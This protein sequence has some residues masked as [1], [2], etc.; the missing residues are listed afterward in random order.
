EIYQFNR[1]KMKFLIVFLAVIA[2]AA[3]AK[4]QEDTPAEKQDN[5]EEISEQFIPIQL[6]FPF[7]FFNR[8]LFSL[9]NPR[10]VLYDIFQNYYLGGRPQAEDSTTTT[11]TVV[12]S[13]YYDDNIAI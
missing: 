13:D 8:P 12:Y 5:S 10:P 7:S 2:F 9:F 6:P 11:T 4:A 1:N 3:I